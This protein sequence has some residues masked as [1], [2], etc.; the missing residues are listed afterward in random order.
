[1]PAPWSRAPGVLESL[2]RTRLAALT[3]GGRSVP[4]G[5]GR[6]R[7][8][9]PLLPLANPA[10]LYSRALADCARNAPAPAATG[11]KNMAPKANSG[12]DDDDDDVPLVSLVKVPRP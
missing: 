6:R 3:C 1:M 4:R 7:C 2:S 11:A 5:R 8:G 10:L 12:W 9:A